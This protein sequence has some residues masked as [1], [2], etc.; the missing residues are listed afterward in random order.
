MRAVALLLLLLLLL[1]A[2]CDDPAPSDA[3]GSPVGEQVLRGPRQALTSRGELVGWLEGDSALVTPGVIRFWEP[4]LTL[5]GDSLAVEARRAW[6][7][8]DDTRVHF[9]DGVVVRS[10]AGATR[11]EVDSLEFDAEGR[12]FVPGLR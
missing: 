8:L 6:S 11:L 4:R 3:T 9:L 10:R 1:C 12:S 5:A 2:A 7:H